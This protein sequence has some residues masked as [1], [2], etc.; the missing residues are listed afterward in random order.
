MDDS[1][2]KGWNKLPQEI[3]HQILGH[4]AGERFPPKYPVEKKGLGAFATVCREWQTVFEQ[5]TFANLYITE[6]SVAELGRVVQGE[7]ARRLGYIHRMLLSIQLEI[8]P[9]GKCCNAET[10]DESD[11]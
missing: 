5:Y 4:V 2:P 7:N 3:R 10:F 8:Y 6:G 9:C 11:E 1:E